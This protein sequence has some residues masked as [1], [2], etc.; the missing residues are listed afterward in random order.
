MKTVS[1]L[2]KKLGFGLIWLLLGL[3]L[4]SC[5]PDPIEIDLPAHEPKLVIATQ[6]FPAK[7]MVVQVS[8]SFSSLA[9]DGKE[10]NADTTF[11]KTLAVE[12]ALVQIN[13]NGQ[14]ET[15]KHVRN[16]FYVS[17]NIPQHFQQRYTL[18]VRDS[19]SG[20]ECTAATEMLAPVNFEK[21]EPEVKRTEKDTTVT[22]HFTL[23]DPG[24]ERNFF[25]ISLVGANRKN[26]LPKNKIGSFNAVQEQIILVNHGA[27]TNGKYE[28][29]ERLTLETSDTLLVS[30][31]NISEPYY[32]Y[33]QL[34]QKS[35]SLMNQLTGEPIN[36]PTNIQNGYGFFS[37]H[38][39]TAQ[40]FKISER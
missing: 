3:G 24:P 27:F 15:L 29:K 18:T 40:V 36:L 28:G 38:N 12:H 20:L 11:L 22:L 2:T 21:L 5:E 25:L 17:R 26:L 37:A 19:V 9:G 35:G 1:F 8:K 16:G 4:F 6:V 10:M 39:P 33:L 31:S 14:T 7:Y 34:Y 13:F 32:N 23:A 30:L